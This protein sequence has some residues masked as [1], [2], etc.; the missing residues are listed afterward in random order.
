VEKAKSGA[1]PDASEGQDR[2]VF[3]FF[4]QIITAL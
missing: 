4:G 2:P 3:C 1:L